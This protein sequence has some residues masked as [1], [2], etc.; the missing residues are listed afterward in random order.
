MTTVPV[1]PT[2][3]A[4]APAQRPRPLRALRGIEARAEAD[5]KVLLQRWSIPALRVAV[6]LV[7][8]VFGILKVIPGASPV[9][10]LVMQTWERLTFG[11]VGGQA[12][13]VATAVIEVTAGVLLI[14]GG[15]FAR[16]GLLVLAL[17]FVGILSPIVLLPGEVFGTAG[18]TLTGQYIFKNI[19]LIAAALVIASQVL[20]GSNRAR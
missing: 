20:R 16:V 1:R 15:G 13:M 11:L 19:V 4:V 5:L 18:P 6:G 9:E 17:A 10:A 3:V 7:F 8:A 12:A 14:A 2:S